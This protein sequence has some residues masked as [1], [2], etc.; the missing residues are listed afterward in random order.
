[1]P[2][3]DCGHRDNPAVRAIRR[4]NRDRKPPNRSRIVSLFA[5]C[6]GMDLGFL[7]GFSALGDYYPHLPFDVVAAIDHDER[8]IE[9]Y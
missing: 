7:G 2:H 4:K 6:G 9:T 3:Y 5:G 1:M 8:A